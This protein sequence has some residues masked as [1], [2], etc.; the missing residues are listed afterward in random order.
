L[1][2][3]HYCPMPIACELDPEGGYKEACRRFI[4]RVYRS[5]IER[6]KRDAEYGDQP[7]VRPALP[8]SDEL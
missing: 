5:S 7:I 1:P 4:R 8:N 6:N 2:W 3:V